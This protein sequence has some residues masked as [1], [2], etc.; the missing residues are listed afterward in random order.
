MVVGVMNHFPQLPDPHFT[1][2]RIRE[3]RTMPSNPTTD[4]VIWM[5]QSIARAAA[6]IRA[7]IWRWQATLPSYIQHSVDTTP[8]YENL[9]GATT[10][11]NAGKVGAQNSAFLPA[12]GTFSDCTKRRSFA[13]FADEI[14]SQEPMRTAQMTSIWTTISIHDAVEYAGENHTTAVTINRTWS[15]YVN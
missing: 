5:R 11:R 8:C 13:P 9:K 7:I 1:M 10:T 4:W 15:A 12:D 6:Y 3:I 14:Q 2:L